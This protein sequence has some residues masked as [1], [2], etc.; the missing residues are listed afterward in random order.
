MYQAGD[1][2]REFYSK[3]IST[4]VRVYEPDDVLN[5]EDAY[6]FYRDGGHL[7]YYGGTNFIARLDIDHSFF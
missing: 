3:W 6:K 2:L 4:G 5:K 1:V 7:S